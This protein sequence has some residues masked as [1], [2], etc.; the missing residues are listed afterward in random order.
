MTRPPRTLRTATILGVVAALAALP[1]PS[2]AQE[3]A[4]AERHWELRF[5]SGSFMPVGEQQRVLRSAPLTAAQLSWTPRPSLAI[6]G[7]L[8]WARSRDRLAAGTPKVDAFTADV[9]AELRAAVG[10]TSFSPFVGVG[11]GSR[12]YDS[13]GRGTETTHNLA[14]YAAVGGELVIRRVGLRV[15]ARDYVTGFK[16]MRD[17][18]RSAVRNE[19]VVMT[20]L[21]LVRRP[22]PQQ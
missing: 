5:T 1:A 14:G 12:S 22:A 6:T 8:G 3:H 13:H 21:R 18:E 9:G 10:R 20:A 16:P 7:T 17:A 4:P 2:A 11:A 15:E 19:V